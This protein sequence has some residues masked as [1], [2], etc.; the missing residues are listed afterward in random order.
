MLNL[1]STKMGEVHILAA[2]GQPDTE[3]V[4]V[5]DSSGR[6]EALSEFTAK[7]KAWH[8]NQSPGH[9][10]RLNDRI[11]QFDVVSN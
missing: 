1:M 2:W 5:P 6:C 8:Q 11:G 7:I 10:D 3:L 4:E 9:F